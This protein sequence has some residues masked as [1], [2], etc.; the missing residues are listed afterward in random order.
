MNVIETKEQLESFLE[1][2]Q[3]QSEVF[4]DAVPADQTVHRRRSGVSF[5]FVRTSSQDALLPVRHN[6]ATHLSPKDLLKLNTSAVKYAYD[7]KAVLHL[8]PF[9]NLV[10]CK[11]LYYFKHNRPP[12][13]SQP[14]VYP[15]AKNIYRPIMRLVEKC[16][17]RADRC[18]EIVESSGELIKKTPFRKYNEE[19]IE[20]LFRVERNGMYSDAWEFDEVFGK[21]LTDSNGLSYS[22]YNLYTQTG[23]P[24]NAFKGVNYAALDEEERPVF[25]SRFDG[26]KM[27]NVDYDAFH[28]R[29]VSALTGYDAPSGSF[30][31]HL[32]K[33]YFGEEELTEED[34]ND[35]KKFT[36]QFLYNQKG[37]PEELL[38]L[39]FFSSVKELTERIWDI[40]QEHGVIS[41]AKHGRQITGSNIENFNPA[42]ALNY[43]LQATSTE[44]VCSQLSELLDYLSDKDTEVVLY[45]YDSVLLDYNPSDDAELSEI[46][47]IMETGDLTVDLEMGERFGKLEEI[48]ID[49]P[50]QTKGR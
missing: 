17:N 29:I 46:K 7:K 16:Q 31:E 20:T 5:V 43:V 42:K 30:H 21:D 25:Q 24:S 8:V 18:K 26:G 2:Y 22:N 40:Y 41:T 15:N 45:L 44:I 23:R 35:A 6:D 9:R 48:H 33:L 4:V 39:R 47:S 28:L 3:D 12:T 10:D 38:Q 14:T 49:E 36:F 34:Y 27:L 13:V 19:I 32:G 1:H 37:I 50:K 11:L